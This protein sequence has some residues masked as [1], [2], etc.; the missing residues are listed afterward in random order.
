MTEIEADLQPYNIDTDANTMLR[1][2]GDKSLVVE[3]VG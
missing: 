1:S 2:K 3:S